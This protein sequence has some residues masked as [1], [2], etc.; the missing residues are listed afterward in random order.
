MKLPHFTVTDDAGERV[1]YSA[2][3][4]RKNLLLV[5]LT[6][7]RGSEGYVSALRPHMAELTAYETAS[8]ITYQPI[9]GVR[10]PA[11]VIA[12]R[13]G[14]VHY[15]ASPDSVA[16]LPTVAELIEWLRYVQMQCPECQGEAR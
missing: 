7:S 12:D 4:Q 9:E 3:W 16:G 15:A 6:E 11:V 14:E 13:W 1:D 2:F 8:V 5:V 10:P